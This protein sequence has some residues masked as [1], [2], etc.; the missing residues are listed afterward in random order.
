MLYFE[1]PL[2]SGLIKPDKNGISKEVIKTSISNLTR[3][4][5][6]RRA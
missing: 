1:M 5:S 4:A 3:M 2:L 6:Q